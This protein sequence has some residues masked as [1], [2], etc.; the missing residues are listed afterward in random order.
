MR[1]RRFGTS[2]RAARRG[3]RGSAVC[4]GKRWPA[5][6]HDAS[7]GGGAISMSVYGAAAQHVVW[8]RTAGCGRPGSESK[9]ARALECGGA[10]ARVRERGQ[11][12]ACG[13]WWCR[14]GLVGRALSLLLSAA[15]TDG[16]EAGALVGVGEVLV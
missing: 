7:T 10:A 9:R 14:T 12:Y 15:A 2:K 16:Q 1:L 3:R 13:V 11:L 8:G 4:E 6:T 5:C